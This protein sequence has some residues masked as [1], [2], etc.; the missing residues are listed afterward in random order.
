MQLP[1]TA[2]LIHGYHLLADGWEGLVW[3][4]PESGMWGSIPRGVVEAWRQKAEVIFW[5]TGAGSEKD[6][7]RESQF[8][9]NLALSRVEILARLC[10]TDTETLR[11][12]LTERSHVDTDAKNT[13]EEVTAFFDICLTKNISNVIIVA[14][15][16][17]APRSL[18]TALSIAQ[19]NERY[20]VFQHALYV[21]PADT[22]FND[23]TV[24]DVVIAEPPHRGDQPKWQTY[25][26]LMAAFSILKQGEGVFEKFLLELGELLRR[27]GVTVDWPTKK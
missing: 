13:V 27:Y 8:I 15:A 12:F 7:V 23:T 6:G 21:A 5:G 9:F 19:G 20:H 18:K 3:N 14:I 2:V 24:N 11:T 17:H 22:S 1:H 10:G 26:Y 4:K 25:R 16:T